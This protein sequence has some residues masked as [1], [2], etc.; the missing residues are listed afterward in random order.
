MTVDAIPTAVGGVLSDTGVGI[1]Q[2]PKVGETSAFH[3]A[4]TVRFSTVSNHIEARSAGGYPLTTIP[5]VAGQ[6]YRIRL[7][8]NVPAHTYD[9]YVTAPGGVEQTI[10]TGLGFR[11]NYASATMLNNF[12]GP[13]DGGSIQL[14]N[15]DSR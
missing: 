11:G 5:W 4:A 13:V 12:R 1:N 2:D 9:A 10:G 3:T 8:L 7:V 15:I 6:S 14:C